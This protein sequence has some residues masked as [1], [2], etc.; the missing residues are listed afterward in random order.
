MPIAATDL[1][2][3]GAANHAEDDTSTQG[4]ARPAR[5]EVPPGGVPEVRNTDQLDGG[6]V[7]GPGRRAG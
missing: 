7:P 5:W 1:K 4:G 3:W 2:F 6:A